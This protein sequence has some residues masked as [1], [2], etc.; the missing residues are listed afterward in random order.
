MKHLAALLL[1][2]A[3][4]GCTPE[5]ASAPVNKKVAPEI[6]SPARTAPV[7]GARLPAWLTGRWGITQAACTNLEDGK[8]RVFA[9]SRRY[10]VSIDRDACNLVGMSPMMVG[11]DAGARLTVTCSSREGWPDY[12]R[13]FHVS[14]PR[15]DV[16]R[17]TRA[18]DDVWDYIRCP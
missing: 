4:A 6:E 16:L 3:A 17:W 1:L 15:P 7:I 14:S 12:T 8:D 5:M 10:E 9:I 11:P 2:G 13:E 18:R